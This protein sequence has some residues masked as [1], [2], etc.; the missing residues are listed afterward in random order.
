M[1][2]E[3]LT[4]SEFST[5]AYQHPLFS[6]HQTKEWGELKKQ[7][8]WEYEFVGLKEK[9]KILAGAILLSKKTPIGKKIFY[10]P[11]GF[12]L[13]YEDE[14]LL[15]E[16]TQEIKKYIKKENGFF[17]KID[18]YLIYKQR[19]ING[20]IVEGG[21]DHSQV[22]ENLKKLGYQHYGFNVTFGSELQPRWIYVLDLKGK[23][24][25]TV[26]QNFSSDTKRYI[27]R[28]IKNG[29]EIEE[30]TLDNLKDFTGIMEHTSKRRGFIN[31]PYSYYQNMVETLGKNV[32][33]LSC[34]L[35]TNKALEKVKTEK[36]VL[37]QEVNDAK[38]HM[39][40]SG[41]KKSKDHYKT[42]QT[43]LE[44]LEQKEKEFLELKEKHG[45][46]IIMASSMFLLFGHEVLYLYSGSYDEFMKYNAQYLIQWEIIQYAVKNGYDRY[47]FYGIEGNFQ[48]ENNDTYGIYEF[49]K[50]FDGN[51]E[52]F[53]GEFDLIISKFYYYLYKILFKTYRST[54]HFLFKLKGGR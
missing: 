19:D 16:F 53:I 9:K 25:E 52:E 32:K 33:I 31:R 37:E 26:F 43:E 1:K 30:V 24:E 20:N 18:P 51:V 41:S 47:N 11:R 17:I 6:F 50:G 22:V 49:K 40:E 46:K 2:L 42:K 45:D 3:K 48:K 15:T 12:L 39:E 29:L 13:D 5:F 8:G 14:K 21:I 36:E 27:H 4:E 7:N 34:F 54:K 28:A 35:D 23:N 10:S 38:I 44:K